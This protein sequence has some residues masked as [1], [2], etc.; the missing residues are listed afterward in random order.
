MEPKWDWCK[1]TYRECSS[2]LLRWVQVSPQPGLLLLPGDS[3]C[4]GK[5][6]LEPAVCNLLLAEVLWV[7]CVICSSCGSDFGSRADELC[8]STHPS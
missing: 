2:R 7:L 4:L 3:V 5:A 1:G 6:Q 8:C